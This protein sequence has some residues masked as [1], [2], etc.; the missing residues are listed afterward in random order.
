MINVDFGFQ[1]Y[2]SNCVF[3]VGSKGDKGRKKEG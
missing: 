3:C 1:V 2:C